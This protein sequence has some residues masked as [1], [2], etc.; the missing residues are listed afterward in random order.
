VDSKDKVRTVLQ[1]TEG[2]ATGQS[3]IFYC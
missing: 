1:R 3:W 2:E